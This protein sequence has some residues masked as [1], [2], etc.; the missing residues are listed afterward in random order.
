MRSMKESNGLNM[1]VYE[2]V[3]PEKRSIL[4][5][6]TPSENFQMVIKEKL[7]VIFF[8]DFQ[9]MYGSSMASRKHFY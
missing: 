3:L 1:H 2:Q 4:N 7:A 5:S 8:C 9:V 6:V